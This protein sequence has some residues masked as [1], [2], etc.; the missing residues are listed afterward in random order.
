[1]GFI[2]GSLLVFVCIVFFIILI[3]GNTFFV[4]SYSLGYKNVQKE[5]GLI[6]ENFTENNLNIIQGDFNLTEKMGGARE[7]MEEHCQNESSYVFAEGGYTFVIPCDVLEEIEENPS[8]IIDQGIENII[9][10]I[11]YDDY[12]C[13][14]WDCFKVTELPFFLIS[15]KAKN[16]WQ[17]KFY[18]TLIAFAILVALIFLLTEH[19]QNTPIIV[20]SLLILSSLPLLKLEKIVGSIAGDSSLAFIGVFFS[21]IG[22]VFWIVFIVGSIL[23]LAGIALKLLHWDFLKKIFSKKDVQKPVKKEGNKKKGD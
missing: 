6:L 3:L 16:Y 7:F 8:V 14:F 20:G 11:Y 17:D 12:D 13:K 19:K 23:I 1:M 9:E 21:R 5:L 4:L 15:E 18:L 2:R 22:G 10:Q